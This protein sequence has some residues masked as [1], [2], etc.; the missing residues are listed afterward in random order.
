MI[1]AGKVT[2]V[3]DRVYPLAETAAA[4]RHVETGH[5]RGKIVV[6]V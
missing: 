3:V 4:I 6:S 5:L 1:D 2:P